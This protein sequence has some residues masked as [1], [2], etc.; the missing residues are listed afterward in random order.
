MA[1]VGEPG[2]PDETCL[3]GRVACDVATAVERLTEHDVIDPSGIDPGP[4]HCLPDGLGGELERV[5]IDERA[6]ECGPDRRSGRGHDD[7]L[8]HGSSLSLVPPR[9][10]CAAGDRSGRQ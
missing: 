2:R 10:P 3:D 4:P 5:D 9:Q 7:C 6:F 8:R 1:V